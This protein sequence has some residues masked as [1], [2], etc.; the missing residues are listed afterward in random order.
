MKKRTVNEVKNELPELAVVNVGGQYYK[1]Y[2]RGRDGTGYFEDLVSEEPEIVKDTVNTQQSVT[3]AQEKALEFCVTHGFNTPLSDPGNYTPE[4]VFEQ[5]YETP[6]HTYSNPDEGL[7]D[8]ITK[9]AFDELDI[10]TQ[11]ELLRNKAGGEDGDLQTRDE[12]QYNPEHFGNYVEWA[13]NH[14]NRYYTNNQR[15]LAGEAVMRDFGITIHGQCPYNPST[16]IVTVFP[17]TVLDN[18]GAQIGGQKINILMMK[19]VDLGF[20]RSKDGRFLIFHNVMTN[21]FV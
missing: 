9:D 7:G 11:S 5:T 21:P 16:G 3:V 20:D 12:Y 2:P 10:D 13:A 14:L 18:Y 1:V 4:G 15:F 19:L 8:D 17:W 6:L